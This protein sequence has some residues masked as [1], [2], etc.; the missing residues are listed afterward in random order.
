MTTKLAAP[1]KREIEVG[2]KPYALTITADGFK[3][4]PKGGRKG[5]EL[6]WS[7]VVE[8]DAALAVALKASLSQTAS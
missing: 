3:L 7:A 4:V 8:G 1:L 5:H 2:G 6:S